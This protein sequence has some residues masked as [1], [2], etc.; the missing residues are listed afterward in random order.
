M[1]ISCCDPKSLPTTH[2]NAAGKTISPPNRVD[3]PAGGWVTVE[4]QYPSI[5]KTLTDPG[6]SILAHPFKDNGAD[7]VAVYTSPETSGVRTLYLHSPG[8]WRI[9]NTG[10]ADVKALKIDTF[11]DA[12][13]AFYGGVRV[14]AIA[15]PVPIGTFT[16]GTFTSTHDTEETV[17]AASE[18]V[19]AAGD[20]KHIWMRN[21]ST[22]GQRITICGNGAAAVDGA[23]WVLGSTPLGFGDVIEWNHPQ[24]MPVGAFNAISSAAGGKLCVSA[25]T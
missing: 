25:G 15:S 14:S 1:S 21:T 7:V 8:Q 24:V 22:G 2:P 11:N 16:P 23:G 5:I 18:T 17:D 19:L 6:A 10:A 4:I 20:W 12:A 9:R 3:L 13:A